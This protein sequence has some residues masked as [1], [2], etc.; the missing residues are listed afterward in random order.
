MSFPPNPAIEALLNELRS[1][2]ELKRQAELRATTQLFEL[3][4][5][6]AQ[7]K[8]NELAAQ[9]A[10]QFGKKSGK[11]PLDA[12]KLAEEILKVARALPE[13]TERREQAKAAKAAAL[14]PKP[15]EKARP[16]VPSVSAAEA[17]Q[18]KIEEAR[19]DTGWS[20]L[21]E[22]LQ[23]KTIVIVGGNVNL[24]RFDPLP[25]AILDRIEWIDTSTQGVRS[26]GNLAS[27]IKDGRLAGLILMEGVLGH[28]HS[29]PL[30][31]AARDSK[32]P[33]SY[34]GKGGRAKVITALAQLD[35]LLSELA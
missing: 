30:V 12:S 19:T 10:K 34:A 15:A 3:V 23:E 22:A 16:Q 11:Y 25:E 18:N 2:I 13:N 8:Q 32:M 20:A 14:A 6:Y 24:T 9:L 35:K 28:K 31:A 7:A 27:R 5:L 29:E 1:E 21:L 33:F 4:G 17:K 26:I